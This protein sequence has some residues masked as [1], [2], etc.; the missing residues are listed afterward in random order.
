M[1]IKKLSKILHLIFVTFVFGSISTLSM[2]QNTYEKKYTQWKEA[3]QQQDQRLKNK[4]EASSNHYLSKPSLSKPSSSATNVS[5]GGS[6][7]RLN[8]ASIEQLMQSNGVGQ[9]KAEAIVEYRN[10]NGKFN[11]VED[12][13]KIKG[14]GPALFNKNK[15]KLAL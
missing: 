6:K 3:Q 4:V 5:S 2:V 11:S 10:Q 12:F 1:T 7:I 9:K 15:D 8:S 13:T 14:V